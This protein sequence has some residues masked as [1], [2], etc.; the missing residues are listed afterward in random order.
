MKVLMGRKLTQ[1]T[2]LAKSLMSQIEYKANFYPLSEMNLELKEQEFKDDLCPKDS[3]SGCDFKYNLTIKDWKLPLI[4]IIMGISRV[5]KGSIICDGKDFTN[6]SLYNYLKI[7]YVPQ[8]VFL[9]DDTIERN[10]ILGTEQV[11]NFKLKKAIKISMLDDFISGLPDKE[12][13]LIGE[14]GI[15]IS[16]G[17]KQRIAIAR[18]LYQ[19]SSL[20]VLDEAT[21]AL[22]LHTE[23]ELFRSMLKYL[24]NITLI[25]V[26]HRE[27]ILNFCK[28]VYKINQ[29]QLNL[30]II[31][32]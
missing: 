7:S 16:G 18:A 26:T 19:D 22:D 23:K 17:Q 8:S 24:D 27:S 30:E 28:K 1:A 21:N 14:N 29:N 3:E 31:K 25:V 5:E 9:I 20:L 11:D 10:I 12:N 32:K 15:K 6:E 4:D 13:T 2:W